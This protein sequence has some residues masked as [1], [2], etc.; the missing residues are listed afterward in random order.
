MAE[1]IKAYLSQVGIDMTIESMDLFTLMGYQMSGE[2][3]A[4]MVD[5]TIRGD[6]FEIFQT[7]C[8]RQR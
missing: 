5:N 8:S 1:A 3:I 4:G 6:D 2:Q 7:F